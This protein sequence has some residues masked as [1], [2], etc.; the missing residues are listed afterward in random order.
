VLE[1]GEK[2]RQEAVRRERSCDVGDHDGDSVASAHDLAERPRLDRVAH[3]FQERRG[4]VREAWH[5]L[6]L[7]DLEAR[8]VHLEVEARRPVL[9]SDAP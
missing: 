4:L 3:G 5:E 2:P 1:L 7:Q 9:E 8:G 6:R